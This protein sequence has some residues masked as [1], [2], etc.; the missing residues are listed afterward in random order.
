MRVGTYERTKEH[1]KPF[2]SWL[3]KKHVGKTK[4]KMSLS[5]LGNKNHNF[6]KHP[7]LETLKKLSQVRT[8]KKQSRETIAKRVTS[9][10]GYRH[11][12]E[13]RKKLSQI[14]ISKKING[15]KIW[16]WKGGVTLINQKIRDSVEYKLWREAV[17]TRDGFVCILC[18]TKK[19]PFNADHI[20]S[21]AHYPELRFSIDNGRTLCVPCHKTTNNYGGKNH[22]QKN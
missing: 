19:S 1:R 12:A 5:A 20:K 16:N 10:K 2:F 15:E 7:S 11:S 17:F 6:G 21:F 18:K 13:T 9:R 4:Q 22:L 8:G 3:G 14:R